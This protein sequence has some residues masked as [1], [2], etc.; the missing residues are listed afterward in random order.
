MS[1]VLVGAGFSLQAPSRGA[2]SIRVTAKPL[3]TLSDTVNSDMRLLL[4]GLNPSFHAADAGYGFA[5]PSNRFWP[6]ALEAQ[7]VSKERDS[8]HA[9]QVDRVGM[10]DLVKKPTSKASELTDKQFRVGLAR[11]SRMCSWLRPKAVCVLGITGWRAA[12]G[13]SKLSLGAQM[14]RLGGRP[15]YV[16]PNPS[17]LN[18][19][20][21]HGDMVKRFRDLLDSV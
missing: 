5:G 7:I 10:T 15:V 21:N 4:V 6:A 2:D 9:L 3:R 16:L 18:A 19:H 14:T 8:I 13:D 12:L 20:T 1:D 17:G 11:I